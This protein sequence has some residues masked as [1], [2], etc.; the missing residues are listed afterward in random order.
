MVRRQPDEE[1]HEVTGAAA[2]FAAQETAARRAGRIQA[3]GYPVEIRRDAAPSRR[4]AVWIGAQ[5]RGRRR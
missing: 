4:S 5:P 1:G 2:A 3:Q